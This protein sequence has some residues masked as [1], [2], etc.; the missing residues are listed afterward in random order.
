[1]HPSTPSGDIVIAAQ[2][3]GKC[4]RIYD[5]P[6]ARLLQ[7]L[8]GERRRLYREFWALQDVSFELARGQTLGVV[9][10][11]GSGKSTLLQ[12]LCSTLIP[13][14]GT[15]AMQGRVGAL[16]ELGS[17]FNP[18]FSGLENVFLNGA[19]LGLSQRQIEERLDD[20]LAFAD[21]GDF[22]HQPVKTYSSGM[23]VRLAFA[24]Q[25]HI[26]P[27]ILV[28]DEALAVGDEMFQ[29]KCY[30]RL[31]DLKRNGTSILLVT[32]NCPQIIQHC[33]QA[34]LLHQGRLHLHDHPK[35]VTTLYQR[36]GQAPSEEWGGLLERYKA[37][38]HE[39]NEESG[40]GPAGDEAPAAGASSRLDPTLVPPSAM[41]YAVRGAEIERVEALDGKGQPA[42]VIP[43]GQPLSVR[44]QARVLE[45]VEDLQVGCNIASHTGLRICGRQHP[46][47]AGGPRLQ[48]QAGERL[49]L[50]FPFRGG[51][52]PGLYFLG[53]GLW[54]SGE[55]GHFLHRLVDAA[56]LR[57]EA[58]APLS[59]FGLC[60]LSAGPPQL[61][62]L[63][64]S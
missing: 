24:V 54:R 19:V 56:A 40:D 9:G 63:P 15:I 8:L 39:A 10:R 23:V 46:G 64:R 44:V 22:V 29:R 34:L 50:R 59:S 14:T 47:P 37:G 1:M 57:V 5:S 36:L 30:N 26:D 43:Q 7:G 12:L 45:D 38:E 6:R 27:D 13:T 42:T 48:A 35:T 11:N 21:I 62:I 16:L 3:L 32:H 53:A 4:Y 58:G 20:I 28:V 2:G 31:E 61:D 41:S 55:P 49:V 25:A 52:M 17:G 51:L 60:D 18:E 33:D